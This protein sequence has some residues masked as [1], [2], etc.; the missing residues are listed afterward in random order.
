MNGRNAQ[1]WLSG[2]VLG[3]LVMSACRK[4][5][6]PE[7]VAIDP[8]EQYA[9]DSA[10]MELDRVS[11][12]VPSELAGSQW[13]LVQLRASQDSVIKP[14]K[15]AVYTVEF[16]ADGQ[17]IVVAG[18]NRGGGAFTVTPPKGLTFGPLATTRAM[19][20]PGSMSARFLADFAKM[21][22]YAIVGGVL[23][24]DVADGGVYQ[25]APE[26]D[27]AR[28]RGVGDEEPE[29]IFACLD[30]LGAESR[31]FARFAGTQP[32]QVSLRRL[33]KSAVA[34][35]VVSG[36]GAKYEGQDVVFWNKG[37]DAMVSWYGTHLNCSTTKE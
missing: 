16:G 19:C 36:S 13:R 34:K 5:K 25:F 18:C 33:K 27:I 2:L 31:I 11:A 24:I 14:E 8:K 15:V 6:V 37:R 29:V 1:V 10:R 9:I 4:D 22:A 32:D 21:R 12:V 28:T 23:Y 17:A 35:Q 3:V 26:L 7:P 20:P 30:S